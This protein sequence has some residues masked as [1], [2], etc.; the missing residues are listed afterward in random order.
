MAP[1]E[2]D[3]LGWAE[4]YKDLGVVVLPIPAQTKMAITEK[5]SDPSVT[6]FPIEPGDNLAWRLDNH[7]DL[8]LDHQ[9]AARMASRLLP[10]SNAISGRQGQNPGHYFY[11]GSELA[12]EKFK[13]PE[14][15]TILEI[16][17]GPGHY[18]VVPPSVMPASKGMPSALS[19][20]REWGPLTSPDPIIIRRSAV[21]LV[22][23][24]GLAHGLGHWG[25]GHDA[26]LDAA[27]FLLR[28]GLTEDE[29]TAVLEAVS[30]PTDN[31]DIKDCA[32]A[33]KS[34]AKRLTTGERE[35][36]GGPSLA[37]R[38]G[39]NGEELVTAIATLFTG[40]RKS[41]GQPWTE[42]GDAETF[43][44]TNADFVR[45]D[46]RRS[47]W[48]LFSAHS[49]KP[50]SDG[51]IMRL[52]VETVRAR[53]V[54]ALNSPEDD[55]RPARVKWAFSGESKARLMSLITLAQ[56]VK[57]LADDGTRWDKEQ[58]LLGC[59]NG[60]LDLRTG[61]LRPGRPEDRITMQVAVPW[62]ANA[63]APLWE[64]TIK[65][66]FGGDQELI[67][68]VQRAGGYSLTNDCR[69]EAMFICWGNGANG[70]G[71]FMNTLT[72]VL[73]DYA[74]DLPASSF[75]TQRGYVIPND[76]AKIET[77]RYVTSS[78]TGEN[79]R[80]NETRIK[81]L[82]GRDQMTARYLYGEFFTFTPVSKFWLATNYKPE[83]RDDSAGFWRRMQMIPFEQSF[84]GREDKTLKDRLLGEMPG[85]LRWLVAGT[86][87]WQAIGLKPPA[88]VKDATKEWKEE[89]DPLSPFLE[90]CCVRS[91][92]AKVG[93]TPFYEAYKK[94][95]QANGIKDYMSQRGFGG[96]MRKQFPIEPGRSVKY[97][98]IGLKDSSP[99]PFMEGPDV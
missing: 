71:T 96:R 24:V 67:E 15:G 43:A 5:W 45:Y 51:E 91:P 40:K 33:V 4:V 81:A 75:E 55:A 32:I 14:I 25:L 99:E 7:T 17:T 56:A 41:G 13:L 31:T 9:L 22:A 49:W 2:L 73:G 64:N 57:P 29:T 23:A 10:K 95:A 61:E 63:V 30:G 93:A 18:T 83:V 1:A 94:W 79:T 87:S 36:S 26:R 97:V 60:V 54:E 66:I 74:D 92:N 53:Q 89:T 58:W 39:S 27:G 11:A 21:L 46:H 98:N 3:S 80:L 47:R 69:E 86:L 12:Y 62:D 59:P 52:A 37:R 88:I 16:R 28:L 38:M 8:D 44:L 19:S 65:E 35:V 72:K 50:Q 90:E 70:K 85:I 48:L 84:E 77:K 6:V 82:T 78:E 34:T 76:L 42:M 68:Y 20:W